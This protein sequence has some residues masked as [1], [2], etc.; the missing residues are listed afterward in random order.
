MF[1]VSEL[2]EALISLKDTYREVFTY[3]EI[4]V[5]NQA[6]NALEE[7]ERKED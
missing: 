7:T 6:C 5:I 4:C 3:D 1:S 2:I